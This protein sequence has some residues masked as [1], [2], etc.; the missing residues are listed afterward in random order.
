M[1]EISVD[2]S[3]KGKELIYM[4][5]NISVDYGQETIFHSWGH[6]LVIKIIEILEH[7]LKHLVIIDFAQSVLGN[8]GNLER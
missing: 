3:Q 8:Q 1:V 5:D 6:L 7:G 2:G 4:L